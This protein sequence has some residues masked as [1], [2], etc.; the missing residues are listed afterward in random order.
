MIIEDGQNTIIPF[1]SLGK[2]EV[3]SLDINSN[4]QDNNSTIVE[5]F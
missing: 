5:I 2:L 4:N 3:I 1:I